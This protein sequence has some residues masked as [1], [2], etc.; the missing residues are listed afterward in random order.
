MTLQ[1]PTT[2][3]RIT[4]Y[5]KRAVQAK[6]QAEAAGYGGDREALLTIAQQWDALADMV[7]RELWPTGHA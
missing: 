7:E 1:P 3:E 5:K 6:A 2:A 4:R